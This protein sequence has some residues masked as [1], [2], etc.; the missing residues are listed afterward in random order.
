M[1]R[2]TTS[3]SCSSSTKSA[4]SRATSTALSTEMLVS[5]ACMAGASLMPSPMKPTTWPVFFSARMIRSFWLGSTSA[6]MAVRSAV[7]QSASSWSSSSWDPV[8]SRRAVE[9][10]RPRDVARDQVVVAGDHLDPDAERGEIDQRARG[11]R[12]GRIREND[13]ALERQ[14]AFVVAGVAGCSGKVRVATARTR[15]PSSLQARNRSAMAARATS[16]SACPPGRRVQ[17]AT[18]G[19]DGAL[20]QQPGAFRRNARPR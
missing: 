18:S 11:G 15:R 3:R 4:A 17:A 1:P 12:L 10:H 9:A 19:L 14:V 5:A 13:E 6:K 8:S 16:S 7:D 20:R 2:R